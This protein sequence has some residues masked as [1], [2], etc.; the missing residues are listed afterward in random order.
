MVYR[1]T[2]HFF[3]DSS[4]QIV[5]INQVKRQIAFY[6]QYAHAPLAHVLACLGGE[7]VFTVQGLHGDAIR[8]RIFFIDGLT[9]V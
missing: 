9:D 6:P 7:N 4:S 5:T 3:L 2:W 8:T 1:S